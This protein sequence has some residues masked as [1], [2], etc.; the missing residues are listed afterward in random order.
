M[1]IPKGRL[2]L[3]WMGKDQALIPS[4]HG[5]YDYDWVSPYDPRACEVKPINVSGAYGDNPDDNLL[6]T[7]DSGDALR[8][9]VTVPEWA[10]KYR[11]KVKLVYI[12][13]P[14][15]T[16]QTF[17]HYADALEHSVWLTLMRDRLIYIKEL[18]ADDGSIW[19]HL[20]DAEVHRMRSLLDEIFGADAHVA[21]V[22][23]ENFYG[24]SSAAA[25]STCHNYLLCYS[26]SGETKWRNT[27]NLLPREGSAL[28]KYQNPDSDPRGPW[29]SGPIFA[30]GTR[31]DGLM[32]TRPTTGGRS[33]SPPKGSHWR[34]TRQ[35]Y[36]RMVTE[37]RIIFG[38]DGSGAPATKLFLSDVQDGLVPR[39]WWPH[40]EVGHSQEGKRELQ[41]LFPDTEPF[42]TPKPERLVQRVVQIGTNPGDIVLDCFAGSGTT[43]AVAHK[44]GR[45]WVAV[46]LQP[47][48][49]TKFVYPR[50]QK[51]V[52]GTDLGG[53]S[54]VKIRTAEE[55]LPEGVTPEEA[56]IFSRLLGRFSV[57]NDVD[58]ATIKT[59]RQ[60]AKT[61][62]TSEATW[63]GGGGFTTAVMS[64]SMY[65]VIDEDIYLTE[66]A[67]NGEFSKAVAGQLGYR[68]ITGD[69][70]FCGLKGR[71][72]LAVLDGVADENVVRSI[73]QNLGDGYKALIVAK[74]VLPEAVETLHQLS[75]GSRIRKAPDEL[76]SKGTV[77]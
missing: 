61:K 5:K 42:D 34:M 49:V 73:L 35:E 62:I 29:R 51:V 6:I 65:E 25:V 57:A 66:A 63:A 24:R 70:V 41:A 1:G 55:E 44:M 39:S 9:L 67:I 45:R 43:A 52:D 72:K 13:P 46:E 4:E 22:V 64:P 26:P 54:S 19:V 17:D 75:H 69:P 7:G 14:F 53:I 30:S 18:L 76:F 59:L 31:H 12:D 50:L 37:G 8:T 77:K 40:S 16:D 10:D 36:D 20:D 15:N 60:S 28:T 23:W 33:F 74:V 3:T 32:D 48:T 21:T 56:S 68:L 47:D 58:E 71:S 27:R 11:G 2:E 38:A